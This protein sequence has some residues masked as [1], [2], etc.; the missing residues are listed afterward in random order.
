MAR[1]SLFFSASLVVLLPV[2]MGCSGEVDYQQYRTDLKTGDR[3]YLYAMP[4]SAYLL[5][6]ERRLALEPQPVAANPKRSDVAISIT[7]GERFVAP[8][9]R[10]SESFKRSVESALATA[11]AETAAKPA[12]SKSRPS[13]QPFVPQFVAALE[14]LLANP[15]APALREMVSAREGESL[16]KL[17][18]RHYGSDASLLPLSVVGY[19][20]KLVN[21]GV[22]FE[23]LQEGE[24]LLLPK[25][26]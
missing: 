23:A 19:Q 7:P 6:I 13:A 11:L 2:L 18:V 17:L 26:R 10:D 15:S 12:P 4:D 3:V 14:Q 16:Q 25:L 5:E 21:P 22:D 8:Q 20:L 1:C 9:Q 24:R